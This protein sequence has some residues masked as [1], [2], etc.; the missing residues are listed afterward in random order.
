MAFSFT[1]EAHG[2]S[3]VTQ[4]WE[5]GWK[6]VSQDPAHSP[7]QE[8]KQM[9]SRDLPREGALGDSS[10]PLLPCGQTLCP[11][12][13]LERRMVP[14]SGLNAGFKSWFCCLPTV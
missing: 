13:H 12:P 10:S 11:S 3:P 9:R 4:L 7:G 8:E 14:Q 5:Q 2:A 6:C 1:E